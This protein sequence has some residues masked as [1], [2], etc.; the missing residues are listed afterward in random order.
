MHTHPYPPLGGTS[1]RSATLV[2]GG[3]DVLLVTV[4]SIAATTGG[5]DGGEGESE[6]GRVR[7]SVAVAMLPGSVALGAADGGEVEKGAGCCAMVS[8]ATA[9]LAAVEVWLGDMLGMA[10]F[11]MAAACCCV[12]RGRWLLRC[13]V[14]DSRRELSVGQARA[15]DIYSKTLA[16][17]PACLSIVNP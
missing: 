9:M 8:P 11:K 12:C 10:F 5:G 17:L 1:S 7:P 14:E 16:S 15:G 13:V 3:V 6:G 4:I 2:I